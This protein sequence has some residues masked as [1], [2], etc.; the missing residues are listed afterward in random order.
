MNGNTE[1]VDYSISEALYKFPDLNKFLPEVVLNDDECFIRILKQSD[2][3]I[4]IEAY[5]PVR[6]K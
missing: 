1:I 2:G 3:G 5:S 6:N 4:R